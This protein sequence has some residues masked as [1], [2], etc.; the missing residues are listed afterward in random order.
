MRARHFLAKITPSIIFVAGIGAVQGGAQQ[1]QNLNGPAVLSVNSSVFAS[2]SP[3]DSDGLGSDI[4]FG[5]NRKGPYLLSWKGIHPNSEQVVRDGVALQRDTDYTFDPSAGVLAFSTPLRA[6][7]MVRVT[8]RCDTADSKPNKQDIS[9]P[10]QWD[11]WKNGANRLAFRGLY[12]PDGKATANSPTSLYALQ[13]TGGMRLAPTSEVTS[14]LFMDL[15]GGDW[16]GR[17][18]LR[19]GEHTKLKTADLAFSYTRAGAQFAQSD[20]SG[21]VAGREVLEATSSFN[22]PRLLAIGTSF[23]QTTEL[24]DASK[25]TKEDKTSQKGTTTRE[26]GG[27][28]GF[29]LPK[30]AGK[31]TAGRNQTEIVTPDGNSVL[32]TLDSVRLEETLTK[33]TQATIGY[34]AQS[35]TVR[36]LANGETKT[37]GSYDQRTLVEFRSRPVDPLLLTGS[38]RSNFGAS[39]AQ[40]VAGLRLE[41]T[42]F[43]KLRDLKLTAAWED[44][45]QD[46]GARRS[47]EAML[48]LP[49]LPFGRTQISGGFRQSSLPGQERV[50]GLVN[51]SSRP[52]RYVE[53]SGNVRVR[54]GM[55]ANADDPDAVNTYNLKLAVRPFQ[56]LKVTGGFTLNPESEDGNL[57]KVQ[58]HT[59]GLE[60]EFGSVSLKGQYGFENEYISNRLQ[61][62]LALDLALRLTAWDTLSTGFQ[63]VSTLS[64]SLTASSTYLLT[65]THRLG[66][67]FDFSLSGSYTQRDTDGLPSPD[68][69]DIKAEAKIG[70]RF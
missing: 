46:K 36:A 11:L 66:T 5:Q 25:A 68:G 3:L 38:F 47:R 19:L 31:F 32:K 62:T 8:Y 64:K 1:A 37:E 67:A 22:F 6:N 15:R 30:S 16:L 39:G 70:L 33:G 20:V 41:T 28:L 63:G 44:R 54:D 12:R 57:R 4:V 13:Y 65:F 48:E 55:V 23:R 61:N 7:Q 53:I 49:T 2:F 17:S 51:A 52:S 27:T 21:L 29:D 45:F 50:V 10:L 59:L 35:N 69:P 60:T 42:P 58:S 34:E 40:D 26:L 24:P 18:G 43:T 14:G 9:L 56:K